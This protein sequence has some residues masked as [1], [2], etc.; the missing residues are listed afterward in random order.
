MR[1]PPTAASPRAKSSP[2]DSLRADAMHPALRQLRSAGM[3]DETIAQVLAFYDEPHRAYHSRVH[4]R[5]MFDQ[6]EALSLPLSAAQAMAVLFHDVIYVPGAPRGSNEAMSAQLML[7]Y[8]RGVSRPIV[9]L[10]YQIV[11][12]TSDHIARRPESE[13]V[14]DLDLLRLAAP[15]EAFIRMSRDVF[16]EHRALIDEADENA[17]WDIFARRRVLFFEKLL[18]R[19]HIFCLPM[20]RERFEAIARSNLRESISWVASRPGVPQ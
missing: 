16:A 3:S 10:A 2:S 4:V 8:A 13:T 14:L 17:A 5:E 19:D 6:S 12:E 15:R 1:Q 11:I 7:V 18:E 20:M 9:E